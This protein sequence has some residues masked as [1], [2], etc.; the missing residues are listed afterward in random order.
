MN[1][2]AF[3]ARRAT[4]S[5][6]SC[7]AA[8]AALVLV[9][10][11]AKTGL[12][13]PDVE[14]PPD[15]T[16]D[17]PD[18][19]DVRDVPDVPD[20]IDVQD[21][22]DVQVCIP[23]RFDLERRGAEVMFVIDRSNSMAFSLDGAVGV[24]MASQR[25]TILNN[26][27]AR[28]LPMYDRTVSFGAKF[29]PQPI[30]P[31]NADVDENCTS[32]PGIDLEPALGN[33]PS[34]LRFFTTTRPGGGT[35]TH[36]G[37]L[38]ASTYLRSRTNRGAARYIVLATDGGPNCNP[39]NP[40][41]ASRC[42]CTSSDPN[43]CRS[44]PMIGIYNCLDDLRTVALVREIAAP[45]TP[46]TQPIPVY[47]VGL[48]GSMTMRADLLAVL[49]QMANAGG[50]PRPIVNPGDRAYYSVRTPGD[51]ERAFDTIVAPLARCAYV[52]PSRPTNPDEIDIEIDGR[53]IARDPMRG[54]GWDWTDRDF[55]EITFYGMACAQAS[56]GN[57]RVRASVGC[58]DL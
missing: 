32:R 7:S 15:A 28:V 5:S 58:R 4:A 25:W 52:T 19:A 14:T 11:G 45:T 16:I 48:D 23:G 24:P 2:T 20:V 18:V 26:S 8:L 35:P 30:D 43:A 36:D 38:Q 1:S 17:A 6:S 47:V 10:C 49:D 40:V 34:L 12:R 51:L 27:L 42:T 22:P 39:R 33:G 57:V 31:G 41:P 37:L 54:E 21:V 50:R 55:G 53:R 3:F 44:N 9:G 56:T 29:Y 46:G 13:V